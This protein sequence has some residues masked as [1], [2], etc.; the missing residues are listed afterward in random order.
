[1]AS[2]S[3]PA[4]APAVAP[5]AAPAEAEAAHAQAPLKPFRLRAKVVRPRSGET[6]RHEAEY[7]RRQRLAEAQSHRSTQREL[8]L[9]GKL[10][11]H[12]RRQQLHSGDAALAAGMHAV[13]L[14]VMGGSSDQGP[15]FEIDGKP[16]P[17]GPRE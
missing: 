4:A 2:S 6:W 12:L 10:L 11:R 13:L 1:M 9:M 5:A 16:A 17:L 15:P 8:K 14:P 3:A 7:Q